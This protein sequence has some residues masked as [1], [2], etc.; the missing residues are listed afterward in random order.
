[1]FV[2]G[3]S[4]LWYAE[5]LRRKHVFEDLQPYVCTFLDCPKADEMFGSQREWFDHQ[6]QLHQREW[7]CDACSE[8][9]PQETSFQEHIQMKHSE[10][11]TKEHFEAVI[12]RS[13]RSNVRNVVCPLCGI[14]L[15]FQT[16]E[17]HLG[18]H[19]QEVA[20]FA[21]PRPGPGDGS[22]ESQSMEVGYSS[23][24]SIEY[25]SRKSILDFDS[26]GT[27]SVD[28]QIISPVAVEGIRCICSYQHN[29]GFLVTCG[30]CRELQHGV[31]MGIN[32]S[33]VP[34]V[35][36]CSACI[37]GAHHLEVEKAIDI[38]ESFLKSSD[39]V[40]ASNTDVKTEVPPQQ[41]AT[42]G[43]DIINKVSG[44]DSSSG[45]DSNR[46]QSVWDLLDF[47]PH[48]TEEQLEET[49]K[50]I[51]SVDQ[52][53]DDGNTPLHLAASCGNVNFIELLR[54]M[55]KI[56]E[57]DF[58]AVNILA[59]T[60]L[61]YA[62]ARGHAGMVEVLLT[63]GA[64][65]NLEDTSGQTA[66]HCAALGVNARVVEMLLEK[67]ANPAAIDI[68]GRSPLHI[69]A[70]ATN[71]LVVR[72]LIKRGG[73]ALP[74][75]HDKD[76][77]TALNL[78][79]DKA[80]KILKTNSLEC[81][82]PDRVSISQELFDIIQE[83]LS[84]E[85]NRIRGWSSLHSAAHSGEI[86]AVEIL[87]K[88]D[89]IL[90]NNSNP[91]Q[92]LLNSRDENG[93]TPADV[94]AC[95]GHWE[96]VRLLIENG[97]DASCKNSNH[98]GVLMLAVKHEI[99]DIVEVLLR[100]MQETPGGGDI[101]SK[102]VDN[103]GINPLHWA[104]A[105]GNR[106][107]VV[108][109]VHLGGAEPTT[110]DKLGMT[111]L[112]FAALMGH[113]QVAQFLLQQNFGLMEAR[114]WVGNTVLH[115]A[116]EGGRLEIVK[117]LFA[118]IQD[119]Y[120]N[121]DLRNYIMQRNEAGETALHCAAR[122][123]SHSHSR[124]MKI[125]NCGT[126][127]GPEML[128]GLDPVTKVW[129]RNFLSRAL[130]NHVNEE[131]QAQWR[132]MEPLFRSYGNKYEIEGGDAGAVALLLL[133]HG[134]DIEATDAVGE[135]PLHLTARWDRL[136]VAETLLQRLETTAN[137]A[138]HIDSRPGD[139]TPAKSPPADSPP[140]NSPIWKKANVHVRGIGGNTPLH[141]AAMCG[142]IGIA[143]LLVEE[144]ANV[145][146]ENNQKQSPEMV[147]EAQLQIRAVYFFKNLK[148]QRGSQLTV[149]GEGWQNRVP[150]HLC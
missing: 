49:I 135:S 2:T 51:S 70:V 148:K 119:G 109:L 81:I 91:E 118:M 125:F 78:V 90:N 134:A 80:T 57:V 75:M 53:D 72:R 92:Q 26:D 36:E 145:L 130:Q 111:A 41:K 29:D 64:K 30:D 86:T 104:A 32:E 124:R 140:M 117:L 33:D 142:R 122:G 77:K 74:T 7:Y 146:D 47:S 93:T 84:T 88:L 63:K 69:A 11:V 17:K 137:S 55:D 60:P 85:E 136:A 113:T 58:N 48:V 98:E 5:R 45:F 20:L 34:E 126:M 105:R 123:I 28:Q 62:A 24:C 54:K 143:K 141:L 38:Q 66:L 103:M 43:P 40:Q 39:Q 96:I 89:R 71:S 46:K 13:E 8:G 112:H 97:C 10:L 76:G 12:S 19:L 1:M 144:G 115:C 132:F 95:E 35:Y 114:N 107:I 101:V 129:H 6:V 128:R 108:N 120:Y 18:L 100:K 150:L 82:P 133:K 42:P 99:S 37:P 67:R 102:E 139:S 61:H 147:A 68:R 106:G 65:V 149:G 52:R 127:F 22:S 44:G 21:L 116:S 50:L 121:I 73:R 9:F 4:L 138:Q 79:L 15:T 56:L 27:Q 14:D 31:C 59:R 16:L 23:E 94:A 87:L 83:L 110:G 25:S 131:Y 3:L